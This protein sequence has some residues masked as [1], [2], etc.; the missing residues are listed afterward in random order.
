M[1]PGQATLDDLPTDDDDSGD[2][3]TP[4]GG[5]ER[6][7]VPDDPQPPEPD[8]S[9]EDAHADETDDATEE[10][11]DEDDEDDLPGPE[12][13]RD[14]YADR[15]PDVDYS[16]PARTGAGGTTTCPSCGAESDKCY[17]CSECGKDL[18]GVGGT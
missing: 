17:R 1:S 16:G 13:I 18:V 3:R 11:T 4:T 10:A 12:E 7:A 2:E 9:R 8:R 5:E 14:P 6:E 15:N